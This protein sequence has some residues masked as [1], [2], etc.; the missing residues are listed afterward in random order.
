MASA[1][2]IVHKGAFKNGVIS[3]SRFSDPPPQQ[4]KLFE[5]FPRNIIFSPTAY[6]PSPVILRHLFQDDDV[7]CKRSLTP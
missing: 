3:N 5:T 4:I 6:T 1:I 2:D 7:I